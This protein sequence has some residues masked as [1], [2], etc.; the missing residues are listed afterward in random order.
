MDHTAYRTNV[1]ADPDGLSRCPPLLTCRFRD[2]LQAG[3]RDWQDKQPPAWW[4]RHLERHVVT[5]APANVLDQ[6]RL[7]PD[8]RPFIA[9]VIWCICLITMW[10][11]AQPTVPTL[12]SMQ[13]GLIRCLALASIPAFVVYVVSRDGYGGELRS[14]AHDRLTV[15]LW[16]LK[17]VLLPPVSLWLTYKEL[18]AWLL[19]TVQGKRWV[20]TPW[21]AERAMMNEL[22]IFRETHLDPKR[23]VL[24]ATIE[25]FRSLRKQVRE[26]R[27]RARNQRTLADQA[28]GGLQ[29]ILA[30]QLDAAAAFEDAKAEALDGEATRLE[31]PID[32][33]EDALRNAHLAH[34][35]YADLLK[36]RLA[37]EATGSLPPHDQT[38]V[39]QQ[40]ILRTAYLALLDAFEG[41]EGTTSE[42]STEQAAQGGTRIPLTARAGASSP[43]S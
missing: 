16:I 36:D 37:L 31:A 25:R 27:E 4:V 7:R 21:D 35:T 41:A 40:A 32:R 42:P 8:A 15:W 24:E 28:R 43:S 2:L 17:Y 1:C 14:S 38:D 10:A 3:E 11:S 34:T 30:Q 6:A 18:V 13:N 20:F 29:A 39:Q 23:R 22:R 19:W 5:A 33:M 9:S 26:A 12:E